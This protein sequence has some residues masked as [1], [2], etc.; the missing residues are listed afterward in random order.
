M[1][2]IVEKTETHHLADRKR[3]WPPGPWQDEPDRVEWREHGFP[4]LALRHDEGGHW[5]GYVGVPPGHPW[6]GRGDLMSDDFCDCHGGV[7]FASPCAHGHEGDPRYVCHVPLPGEP[8][9]V[10]WIGFDFAHSG[11]WSPGWTPRP[12]VWLHFGE[13]YRDLAYVTAEVS[14]VAK[15][16]M[17]AAR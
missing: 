8:A 1:N 10:W 15:Q 3:A 9:E 14:S 12:R 7:T 4:C 11:D 17:E 16:A 6:H 2:A 5:C 13:T